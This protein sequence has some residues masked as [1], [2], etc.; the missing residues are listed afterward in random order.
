MLAKSRRTIRFGISIDLFFRT[1]KGGHF[2]DSD[3]Q[4]HA[5]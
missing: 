5:F 1:V 2:N 4:L 3:D